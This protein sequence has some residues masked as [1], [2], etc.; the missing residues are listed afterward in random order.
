[1]N[2]AFTVSEQ[3]ARPTTSQTVRFSGGR[4]LILPGEWSIIRRHRHGRQHR[5]IDVFGKEMLELKMVERRLELRRAIDGRNDEVAQA[6]DRLM[7]V[8]APE[9]D[10]L[11]HN[12]LRC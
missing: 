3:M 12:C 8:R 5:G 11:V 10:A 1:M 6:L 7:A 4:C 9:F 2:A